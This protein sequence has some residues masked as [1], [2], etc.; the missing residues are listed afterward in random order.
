VILRPGGPEDA[1][2]CHAVYVTAVREGAAPL[3]SLAE[4]M[5]WAPFDTP[6]PWMA[7][8]LASG[9]T[10][11]AEAD[12]RLMGFLTATEA[13]HLDLFFVRPEARRGPVAPALYDAFAAWAAARGL[14]RLTTHASA[15]ARRF[16]ERR[17]WQV[18]AEERVLRHGVELT[19]W[20]MALERG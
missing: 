10:W 12:G 15:L 17:G 20:A 16:L 4:R 2:A 1:A 8:R 18:V 14:T 19:R 13:G 7:E 3:Y 6:E 9:T 5:A 11:L